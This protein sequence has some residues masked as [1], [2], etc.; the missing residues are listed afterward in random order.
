LTAASE[1]APAKLNLALHVRGKRADGRHAIETVFAFC[2]D[3]DR[4]SAE[5]GEE[6][7]LEVVGPF[8]R[9]IDGEN[10]VLAAA[11]RL[12]ESAGVPATAALTLDKRLPVASGIG[13]GSA[14]AGAALRLLTALWNFTRE[15]AERVAQA[16]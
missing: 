6:L 7:L 5:R 9:D 14:D 11:A 10:L 8:A 13:G 16:L 2:T 3:G 12:A 15:H 1:I 4:L